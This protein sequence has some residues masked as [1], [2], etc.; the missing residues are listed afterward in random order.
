MNFIRALLSGDETKADSVVVCGLAALAALIASTLIVAF[1][2]P[3]AFSPAGFAGGA[4]ALIASL[5][6]GKTAR[7][8]W[9]QQPTSLAA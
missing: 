7:D 6:G 9:S 1:L 4:S 5:A 3:G 2:D 8:R